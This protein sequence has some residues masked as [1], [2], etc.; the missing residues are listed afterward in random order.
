MKVGSTRPA[1]AA[2]PRTRRGR[3]ARA[4][5]RIRPTAKVCLA[6]RRR[7]D[8]RRLAR[9]RERQPS[10]APRRRPGLTGMSA[11]RPVG[12]TAAGTSC[13][14]VVRW[15]TN[16]Q[17]V[18]FQP[19]MIAT[20]APIPTRVMV[21]TE[22]GTERKE[23]SRSAIRFALLPS[24]KKPASTKLHD[25]P[26]PSVADRYFEGGHPGATTGWS[27]N[28]VPPFYR[29]FRSGSKPSG[30]EISPPDRTDWAIAPYLMARDGDVQLPRFSRRLIAGAGVSYTSQGRPRPGF[31]FPSHLWTSRPQGAVGQFTIGI[32]RN[33]PLCPGEDYDEGPK[34]RRN[35]GGTTS[36][37]M[38]H[39]PGSTT[40]K[41]RSRLAGPSAGRDRPET[42]S[43]IPSRSNLPSDGA[44]TWRSTFPGTTMAERPPRS[45]SGSAA[46]LSQ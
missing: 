39:T 34:R 2:A 37:W 29:V 25:H 46:F 32:G 4:E 11:T 7:S 35:S 40:E 1:T 15:G 8:S 16:P 13:S 27:P 45:S 18:P 17:R 28:L 12:K 21:N 44:P 31:R 20:R 23:I 9:L 33:G 36:H 10:R 19:P 14:P 22:G 43:P 24:F 30:P 6:R 5:W 41:G 26:P 3:M 42:S 38:T